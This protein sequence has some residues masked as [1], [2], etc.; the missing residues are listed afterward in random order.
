MNRSLQ[1]A[2]LLVAA[3]ALL[4]CWVLL[5]FFPAF[6]RSAIGW[7]GVFLVGAP[8]LLAAEHAVEVLFRP[9]F[10]ATWPTAARLLYG[11]VA[12]LLFLLAS[13]PVMMGV[14]ALLSR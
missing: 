5:A 1:A 2:F 10:L 8:L 4:A 14:S 11:V 7:L 6:P 12:A 9:A 3:A 13:A